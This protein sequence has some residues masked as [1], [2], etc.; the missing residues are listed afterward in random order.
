ME[1]DLVLLGYQHHTEYQRYLNVYKVV[2][3]STSEELEILVSRAMADNWFPIGG[4]AIAR[5]KGF[6]TIYAQ[7]MIKPNKKPGC[8]LKSLWPS[9]ESRPFMVARWAIL[10]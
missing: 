6:D 5:K 9:L 10:G 2:K 3:S 7:A 4:V 8:Q 1:P